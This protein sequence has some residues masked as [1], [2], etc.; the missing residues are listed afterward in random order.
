MAHSPPNDHSDFIPF[1]DLPD[2]APSSLNSAAPGPSEDKK[3][4]VTP[5]LEQTLTTGIPV[6]VGPGRSHHDNAKESR[7]GSPRHSEWMSVVVLTSLVGKLAAAVWEWCGWASTPTLGRKAAIKFLPHGYADDS[8]ARQRFLREAQVAAKIQHPH[9]VTVYD[10]GDFQG[11]L[12][13]AME[14]VG[15]G[16]LA[17]AVGKLRMDV[18]IDHILHYVAEAAEGLQCV[19]DAGLL[20]RDI[21]PGNILLT[22]DGHA[23]I[24]DFGLTKSEEKGEALTSKGVAVGTVA[25]MAPELFQ[26][27]QASPITDCYALGVTLYELL[28]GKRPYFGETLPELMKNICEKPVP[29][30][31]SECEDISPL[32]TKL[33]MQAIA[34]NPEHR[35]SSAA[36]FAKRLRS[37]VRLSRNAQENED[38]ALPGTAGKSAG[39]ATMNNAQRAPSSVVMA[40]VPSSHSGAK[41]YVLVCLV[42]V[43]IG[44][45]FLWWQNQQAD[46]ENASQEPSLAAEAGFSAGTQDLL[47]VESE[48]VDSLSVHALQEE[49]SHHRQESQG[50]QKS[51]EVSS[52]PEQALAVF[53]ENYRKDLERRDFIA[54]EETIASVQTAVRS[55]QDTTLQA[56]VRS[57]VAE[58]NRQHEPAQAQAQRIAQ[59][60]SEGDFAQWAHARDILTTLEQTGWSHLVP[61]DQKNRLQDQQK[62]IIQE[63]Q[64]RYGR[65]AMVDVGGGLRLRMRS[66]PQLGAGVWLS[67]TEI[68]QTFAHALLPKEVEAPVHYQIPWVGVTPDLFKRFAR[69]LSK[70]SQL[71]WRLPLRNEWELACRS[72][73]ADIR[74]YGEEVHAAD[75]VWF[76]DN[77]NGRLQAVGGRQPNLYGLHDMLGNAAELVPDSQGKWWLLGGDFTTPVW[78]IDEAHPWEG[79]RAERTGFRLLLEAPR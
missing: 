53:I 58:W 63:G 6:R 29:N 2:S 68:T 65:W 42:V 34:K 43:V 22:E 1:P 49:G 17:E 70:Q 30:P 56:E 26:G 62:W 39:Y 50:N 9:V 55:V 59:I 77:A 28:V 33:V 19:H 12:F 69:A 64:D 16:S 3:P 61:E 15:G 57:L 20:H 8:E 24:G 31:A 79:Y 7:D 10:A 44:V 27:G 36:Q 46:S 37:I 21:K 51:E 78:Y 52:A 13:I 11:Q 54:A 74:F 72:G 47:H 66:V 4:T 75:Y 38:D 35:F 71:T 73:Q 18:S 60:I 48:G 76:E 23:K 5:E 40:N 25:Y 14:F 67:E 41:R 32:L 45:S